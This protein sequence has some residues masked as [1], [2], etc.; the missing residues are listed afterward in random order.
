MNTTMTL[1]LTSGVISSGSLKKNSTPYEKD[2]KRIKTL[3]QINLNLRL[4]YLY[5]FVT[6]Y[7]TG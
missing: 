1:L 6:S 2:K 5:I 7:K 4:F 3:A